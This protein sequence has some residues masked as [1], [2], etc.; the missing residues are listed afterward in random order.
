VD[1]NS[2]NVQIKHLVVFCIFFSCLLST[3]AVAEVAYVAIGDV[4]LKYKTEEKDEQATGI[5]ELWNALLTE[6]LSGFESVNIVERENLSIILRELELSLSALSEPNSLL[7]VQKLIGADFLVLSELTAERSAFILSSRL[8]SAKDGSIEK[9]FSIKIDVNNIHGQV[10]N[11][12]AKI[13]ESVINHLKASDITHLIAITD[14]ENNSLLSR[15]D[16]METSVSRRLRKALSGLAGIRIL[17]REE[18]DLLLEEVRLS[19]GGFIQKVKKPP[20]KNTK[21]TRRFLVTGSYDEYQQLDQHLRIDFSISIRDIDLQKEATDTIDFEIAGFEGGLNSIYN[22][23][24]EAL[25]AGAEIKHQDVNRYGEQRKDSEAESDLEKA[26]QYLDEEGKT[27]LLYLYENSQSDS[28]IKYYLE[29]LFHH[30]SDPNNRYDRN[31]VE[32]QV[33]LNKAL[34]LMAIEGPY[35]SLTLEWVIRKIRSDSNK[36]THLK[37]IRGLRKVDA[38]LGPQ[39]YRNTMWDFGLGLLRSTS[40]PGDRIFVHHAK[41]SRAVQYL[42]TAIMLDDNNLAAKELLCVLLVD[43]KISNLA[44]AKELAQEIDARH[45]HSRH[46]QGALSFLIYLFKNDK[47]Q[48]KY[49]VDLLVKKYPGHNYAQQVIDNR[50]T[51]AE[52]VEI[53]RRGFQKRFT[54]LRLSLS[55]SE[56]KALRGATDGYFVDMEMRKFFRRTQASTKYADSGEKV[57][58]EMVKDFPQ[59]AILICERWAYCWRLHKQN[60]EKIIYWCKRG[61]ELFGGKEELYLKFRG[62]YYEMKSMLG[63]CFF[64]QGKYELALDTLKEFANVKPPLGEVVKVEYF[65]YVCMYELGRYEEALNGFEKLKKLRVTQ[66]RNSLIEEW[67][68]KCHKALRIPEE[69]SPPPYNLKTGTW[70]KPDISISG[71]KNSCISAL[72]LDGEDIWI[73]SNFYHTKTISGQARA[74]ILLEQDSIKF[75]RA[76]QLAGLIRYNIHTKQTTQ[77]EV[78]KEISFRWIMCIHAQDGHVWVGTNGGGIDVYDKEMGVWSNISEN[79]GLPSNYIQCLTADDS[80]LWIGTGFLGK[81]AV[82]RLDLKTRNLHTFLPRAYRDQPS[83]PTYH[84][85]DIKIAEDFLWCALQR[86]GVAM[87]DK[88]KDLWTYYHPGSYFDSIVIFKD[89]VWFSSSRDSNLWNCK[90]NGEDWKSISLK[91]GPTVAGIF[92]LATYDNQLFIGTC[93]PTGHGRYSFPGP[94]GLAIMNMD[95]VFDVY[96]ITRKFY[97]KHIRET[98]VTKILP[99]SANE[100]WLGLPYGSGVKILKIP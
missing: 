95:G 90:S 93:G 57:I 99:L 12:A 3:T 79:D 36:S 47:V 21:Y 30:I 98:G 24:V 66:V 71:G 52:R 67:I 77:F 94:H 83:P 42:K 82:A 28:K 51:Q 70:V 7:Q 48:K 86:S 8:V 33:Y 78:G 39:K 84:I 37:L 73:G 38:L 49:Y 80:Y 54:S 56:A 55:P 96:R 75:K 6:R 41:M 5:C 26:L 16:W 89:R 20:D 35:G 58:E 13:K 44:L 43:P 62:Q 92:T 87:Y 53:M 100:I 63:Q 64:I 81:G 17:E 65:R 11:T 74:S 25:K 45:P 9:D 60:T 97:L 76:G 61:L 59:A 34:G 27:A 88:K 19:K 15:N 68:G 31:S 32:S 22:H 10:D 69:T 1:K 46:Q 4:H 2:L 40:S 14:F 23:I 72:T 85:N 29:R 50:L 91:D 18:V